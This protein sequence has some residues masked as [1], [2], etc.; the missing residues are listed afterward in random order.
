MII[1]FLC[2]FILLGIVLACILFIVNMYKLNEGHFWQTY[3]LTFIRCCKYNWYAFWVMLQL[4]KDLKPK[5][6]KT[7]NRYLDKIK[8]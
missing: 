1:W 6:T 5:D 7:F 3:V 8:L 4:Y 2:G